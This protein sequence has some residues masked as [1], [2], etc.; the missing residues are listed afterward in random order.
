MENLQVVSDDAYI[1][2]GTKK[3]IYVSIFFVYKT[4]TTAQKVYDDF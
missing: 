4:G 1:S 2:K 3:Y